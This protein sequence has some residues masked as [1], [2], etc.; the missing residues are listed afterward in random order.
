MSMIGE[1]ARIPFVRAPSTHQPLGA[2]QSV[3]AAT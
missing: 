2:A 1:I 3:E